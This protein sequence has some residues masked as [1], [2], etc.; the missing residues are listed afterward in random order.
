MTPH[1]RKEARADSARRTKLAGLWTVIAVVGGGF[2]ASAYTM[3][4]QP[5][6]PVVLCQRGTQIAASTIV[7]ADTT[8]AL[9]E[10]QSRRLRRAIEAER[11]GMPRGGRLP[12]IAINDGDAS[13]PAELFSGCNPGRSNDVN[14]L[15][16]TAG[17]VDAEWAATFGKPVEAATAAAAGRPE[18]PSS[19]LI[20]TTA[21]LLTR[22]DFDASVPHRRLVLVSDMVEHQ[23][24]GYSHL[25]GGDLWKGYA[26]SGLARYAALDLRGVTVAIDYLLRPQYAALQGPAHRR[27]RA[28]EPGRQHADQ[29]R[30]PE[31]RAETAEQGPP[32]L[33]ADRRVPDRLHGWGRQGRQRLLRALAREQP[34]QHR[35][36]AEHLR[37]PEA[38]AQRR[39]RQELS[40]QLR[41]ENLPAQHRGGDQPL[42]ERP[43]RHA[44]RD[45]C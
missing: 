30:I 5:P 40:R 1:P 44:F 43:V 19:P 36:G 20:A 37:L 11:D 23:R 9:T 35:R 14:P 18:T 22:P 29:A 21:A 12:I 33:H 32:Q 41:G 8:D 42:G 16:V 3:L 24:G 13:Q 17:K 10:I 45:C 34:R 7:L 28:H 27:P 4:N 26:S 38:H 15:F 2:A 31:A 6:D 39:R 25:A